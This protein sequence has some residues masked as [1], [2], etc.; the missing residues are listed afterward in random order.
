M[1][2]GPAWGG[3][4]ESRVRSRFMLPR[5]CHWLQSESVMIFFTHFTPLANGGEK[6]VGADVDWR[7]FRPKGSP[8]TIVMCINA[9]RNATWCVVIIADDKQVAAGLSRRNQVK[10]SVQQ[11]SM[12]V[13]NITQTY[14]RSWRF[15]E[16]PFCTRGK[17][18]TAF[19]AVT[20]GASKFLTL[21]EVRMLNMCSLC[22]SQQFSGERKRLFL[23]LSAE[24]LSK[25]STRD[26]WKMIYRE[27]FS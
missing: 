23:L 18:R 1:I 11:F 16:F 6:N 2:D 24:S 26:P 20:R 7:L 14:Q 15:N 3:R 13:K 25:T 9:R 27:L 12:R 4:A 8:E 17:S 22:N 19:S 5:N 21:L 10:L